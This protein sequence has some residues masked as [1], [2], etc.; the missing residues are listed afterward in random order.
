LGIRLPQINWVHLRKKS[1]APTTPAPTV[2]GNIDDEALTLLIEFCK[3]TEKLELEAYP[4]PVNEDGLPVTVGY[5]CTKTRNGFLFQV[6]DKITE[7]EALALLKR[8]AT[9][10]YTLMSSIPHWDIMTAHQRAALASLNFNEGYAYGDG[11]HDTLDR[12]LF[13]RNWRDVGMALQLYDNNDEL[14]LSR[15]RY[16]E[17]LMFMH[18]ATPAN[19]YAKSWG[20]KS[21]E[22]IMRAI[23]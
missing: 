8:D 2:G 21:V 18:S 6:G 17:W 9:E 7:A 11:D 20:M 13:N 4:D 5:G 10:A 14:G 16:A 3:I 15:R 1:I 19:A 12:V 23:T 22:Q